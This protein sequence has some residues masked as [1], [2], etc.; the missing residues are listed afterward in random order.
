M[1]GDLGSLALDAVRTWPDGVVSTTQGPLPT[2]DVMLAIAGAESGWDA[3]AAGDSPAQ[4]RAAGAP[5]STVNAAYDWGCPF[6]GGYASW[7]AWQVFVPVHFAM[8]RGLMGDTNADACAIARW[9]QQGPNCVKAANAILYGSGL[10]AWSTY[11]QGQWL[12]KWDISTA[13]CQ[14]ARAAL[15]LPY[16]SSP[17]PGGLSAGAGV[18][19]ALLAIVAALAAGK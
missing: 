12:A 3:G 8:V 7:G 11:T 15:G 10:G 14:S 17:V 2:A 13:A 9:L 16:P 18:G 1:S 5:Q 6:G 19:L 4:L